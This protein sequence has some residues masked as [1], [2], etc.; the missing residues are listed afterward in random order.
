MV[1][2]RGTT[3]R[4]MTQHAVGR[5]SGCGVCNAICISRRL[6]CRACRL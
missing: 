1:L 5:Q 4:E 3:P 2:K 6:E